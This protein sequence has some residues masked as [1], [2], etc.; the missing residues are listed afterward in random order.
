MVLPMADVE[1]LRQLLRPEEGMNALLR[2]LIREHFVEA[3]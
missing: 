1:K 3:P 2:R